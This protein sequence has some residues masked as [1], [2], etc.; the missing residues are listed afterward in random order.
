MEHRSEFDGP[1]VYIGS[2]IDQE[3][4]DGKFVRIGCTLKRSKT[5][6]VTNIEV[7]F[8]GFDD[9]GNLGEIVCINSIEDGRVFRMGETA[10]CSKQQD[11]ADC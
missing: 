8:I 4:C 9:F 2:A 3:L 1:S 11:E 7:V 5:V 6:L 10:E